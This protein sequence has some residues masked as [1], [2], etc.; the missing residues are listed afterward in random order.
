MTVDPAALRARE[1]GRAHDDIGRLVSEVRKDG[2]PV[3][4]LRCSD[5]GDQWVVECDVYPVNE[6]SVRPKS[7][8]PYV[9]GTAAEAHEFVRQSLLTLRVFG[10]DVV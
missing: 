8:G 5:C 6:L 10:C 3:V 9:F 1:P 4:R 7:A 2:R